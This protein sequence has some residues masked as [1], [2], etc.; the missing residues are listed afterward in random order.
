MIIN[1][2][3][4]FLR[5]A[6]PAALGGNGPS[7]VIPLAA[8]APAAEAEPAAPTAAAPAAVETP[9]FLASVLG[10]VQ[11]KGK[12]VA[13][14][15]AATQRAATAEAENATLRTQLTAANGELATL[16]QERATIQAALVT[17]QTEKQDLDIAA[18]SQV[19]ALGFDAAALPAAESAPPETIASLEAQIA[20]AKAAG[21]HAKVWS[22]AEKME[23][24]NN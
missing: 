11:A 4:R 17:A 6:E 5:D 18:A 1:R 24:I 12:L 13:E 8:A 23:A 9:G 15:D 10:S 2:H 3:N 19:A 14:R 7:N 21:D 22:L 20:T 16:K